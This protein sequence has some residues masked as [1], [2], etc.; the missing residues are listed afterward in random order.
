MLRIV[1]VNFQEHVQ[2]E[3]SS[4]GID[5]YFLWGGD[6][7]NLPWRTFKPQDLMLRIETIFNKRIEL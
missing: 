1:A 7:D 3:M 4:I 6:L 5:H 2:R